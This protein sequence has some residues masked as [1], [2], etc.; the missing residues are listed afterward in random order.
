LAKE[1]MLWKIFLRNPELI[2]ITY[3]TGKRMSLAV[4][5]TTFLL[6]HQEPT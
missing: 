5:V 1:K 2:T 6:K 3:K 4:D